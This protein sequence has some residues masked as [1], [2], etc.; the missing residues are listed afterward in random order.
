VTEL[1]TWT[2]EA[3][4]PEIRQ[5][6]AGSGGWLPASV[7]RRQAVEEQ[8]E[9]RAERAQRAEQAD[10]VEQA[11]DR[12]VA[13]YMAGAAQRGET[14]SAMDAATG[15]IGRTLAEVLS[16]ATGE[17]ADR[18]P[19]GERGPRDYEILG[20]GEPVIR[21]RRYDDGWPSSSYEC[22]SM[23]RRA[24][25]L[26]R[27]LVMT[28]QRIAGAAGRGAEHVEAERAKAERGHGR[29]AR[30]DQPGPAGYTAPQGTSWAQISDWISRG[31]R[32]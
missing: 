26:H 3:P 25:N 5:E 31:W 19:K 30:R 10:R 21:S 17:L 18:I 11:H 9:R 27:D 14:V 24:E 1:A 15:N 23:L 16:G 13:A 20:A 32:P 29:D 8:A 6:P 2:G 12:A 28:Q 4:E 22:D 7:R